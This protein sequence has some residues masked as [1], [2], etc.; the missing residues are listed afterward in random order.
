MHN[1]QKVA[2]IADFEI[3][4]EFH[5][6]IGLHFFLRHNHHHRID[7][8][9]PFNFFNQRDWLVCPPHQIRLIAFK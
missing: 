5:L 8:I 9:T 2:K 1:V 7:K 3:L 4:K 6:N